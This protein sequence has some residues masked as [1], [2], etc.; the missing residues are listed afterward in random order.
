MTPE[1]AL[2]DQIPQEGLP[3]S[4]SFPPAAE[5]TPTPRPVLPFNLTK[6]EFEVLRLVTVGLTSAQIAQQLV[7]S[8]TTVNSYLSS[9]YSKLGVSSRLGAMRY[10]M[11]N[12]LV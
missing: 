10:A 6:R 3:V 11:D 7:I 4:A 5:T 12:H 2:A 1:Q 8:S 9:I